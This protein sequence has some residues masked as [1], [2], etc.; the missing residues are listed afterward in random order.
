MRAR[1]RVVLLSTLWLGL[2]PASA[3]DL[4]TSGLGLWDTATTGWGT[5]TG[6][7]Y[8]GL[9]TH[10]ERAVFEGTA[11]SV[12]IG[13]G[14][15]TSAG[16]LFTTPGYTLG[17]GTLTLSTPGVIV[18]G[19]GVTTINSAI[20]SGG[21]P[22]LTKT[23]AGTL[24]L[25]G[26]NTFTG[27][28][29]IQQGVVN[30]AS[31][32]NY[33]VAGALG[34]RTLAMETAV[35]N[36]IG[37]H[38]NGGTLQ[39]TGST[40]QSTDRHIRLITGTSPTI[41]ASGTGAG[42]LSFTRTGPNLNL[43]DNPGTR[44]LNLIGSNTGN[45]SFSIRLENQ[46]ASQTTLRKA[47]VGKWVIANS[48]NTY[49]GETIFAG[50]IL[51]VASLSDYGVASSIGART[52]AEEN[53]GLTGVGLHFLGGTLQYTGATPQS[54]DRHIRILN[55][56]G[57]TID[58][59]G[60][61]P[62]A[63]LSFTRTGPNMN[64]FDTGGARTLTLTGT[65]PGDNTFSLRLENQGSNPTGLTKTGP[66]RWILNASDSTN[67]GLTLVRQG[68]LV[69][70]GARTAASGGITVADTTGQSATLDITAGSFSVGGNFMVAQGDSTVLGTVNQSGGS[71]SLAAD[72]MLVGNGPGGRGTYNL[73]AGTVTG[74]GSGTRGVILG[75]NTGT[76]GVFNLSGTGTLNLA[77][78]NLQVARSENTP[79]TNA[80]GVFNQTGG[81]ALVGTLGVG[82]QFAVN[83]AGSSGVVNLTGG[84]FTATGFNA[85]AGGDNSSAALTLGGSATVTLPAFPTARGSGATA[86]VL[87]DGGVL[88]AANSSATYLENMTW[89]RITNNGLTFDSNGQTVSINQA[90]E[91]QPSHTGFLTKNGGGT[92]T[93]GGA[94]A[95]TFT[96]WVTI[97]D[98]TLNLAKSSGL[99]IQGNV[100]IGNAVGSDVLRLGASDQIADSSVLTFTAG[101]AAGT[102]AFLQMNGQ[103]ETVAGIQTS[104]GGRVPVIENAGGGTGI[105]TVNNSA[106]FTFDGILRNSTGVF[107]LT[108]TGAGTLT[109][110]NTTTVA[111]I[112]Y[113]GPT[114]ISGGTLRLELRDSS[115]ASAVDN[116]STLDLFRA[117][118]NIN[119]VPAISGNG[120]LIKSGGGT[121]SLFGNSS[122]SGTT[123]LAG[124]RL[125]QQ[126]VN[127][128]GSG[129]VNIGAGN[130]TMLWW[131][132]G[133]NVLANPWVLNGVGGLRDGETKSAIYA[134]GGGAGFTAV[135]YVLTGPITLAATSDVGGWANTAFIA[136]N[137]LEISGE[138]GGP[139][140]LIKDYQN[141]VVLSGGTANTYGGDTTVK[142]GIL[143]LAKPDGVNA[144]PGNV[145]V[146]DGVVDAN[147]HHGD[148]LRLA[149]GNQ[150][151]DSAVLT[152]SGG[153]SAGTSGK[154]ELNGFNETV[155]GLA[156]TSPVGVVQI[157]ETA[158]AGQL[159]TLTINNATHHSYAGILRNSQNGLGEFSLVKN[160][161]GTQTLAGSSANTYTGLTTV[162]GGTLELAKSGGSNAVGGHLTIGDGIGTDTV[163]W[164][165]NNMVADAAIITFN[166]GGV[167]QING[168]N[169]SVG[170]L[171]STGG[172][173]V[174]DNAS[175]ASL[176]FALGGTQASP[177]AASGSFSGTLTESGGGSIHLVKNGTGTQIFTSTHSYTGKTTLNG[178]VL[179]ITSGN[180]NSLGQPAPAPDAL[181]LNGGT[182]AVSGANLTLN[183]PGRNTLV[184]IG[185]GTFSVASGRS[186]TLANT[187]DAT[188]TSLNKA[189]AGQL[190]LT[191]NTLVGT[192]NLDGG[193]TDISGGFLRVDTLNLSGGTFLWGSGR[194]TVRTA[195]AQN[196][197][198]DHTQPGYGEVRDGNTLQVNGDLT[199]TGGAILQ[200]HNS[201]T[202]YINNGVRF[203]GLNVEG[204]LD[205][206]AAG[207][208]LAVEINPY[209]LRPFA[210]SLGRAANEYG[211]IPLVTATAILGTF[212]TFG[213]VMDDGMGFSLTT[214]V[215]T[216]AAALDV[217]TWYLQYADTDNDLV[218]DTLFFHYRVAGYVPEPGSFS[219]LGGG[220]LLLR[221]LRRRWAGAGAATAPA[222]RPHRRRR[223]GARGERLL[224][225]LHP[226]PRVED[227]F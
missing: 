84:I 132:T 217:N 123:T 100:Q 191:G 39:Y 125:R 88:R 223:S 183:D 160:G 9:W 43:F 55:G 195:V 174:L 12:T 212:D 194:L 71:L 153:V 103:S 190:N 19:S 61:V 30:V 166:P 161:V 136:R 1:L 168:R 141:D 210:P 224:P 225:V 22:A 154:F 158:T 185:G 23:G 120:Q 98:G 155:A 32:T 3:A 215:F 111:P 109:L 124:G 116:D 35:G 213:S 145:I 69:L 95:N 142:N 135:P 75:V 201:P 164:S 172:A 151:P 208:R 45:N 80:T 5:T 156:G 165:A 119:F 49:T 58:A 134:D 214:N 18:P 27:V 178:G 207:D 181:I 76:Q 51:N 31:L 118:G 152:V 129:T 37:I 133:S 203:N 44:T 65:N 10:G 42:T 205:L 140:G 219:L 221:H 170:A 147:Y 7:P 137:S 227:R 171:Q 196:G 60:S 64:L 102:S 167:A 6:G 169:E 56:A 38:L 48:D 182:L 138:I 90:L 176:T 184:G 200:L 46:A 47:G 53:T 179:E 148:I 24:V 50:G 173:G 13:G 36:G 8:G 106:N 26:P 226:E 110:Q 150:I 2:R 206:S 104:V 218:A 74:A 52:L 4:F 15:V 40:P 99:A 66:G 54:T 175:A 73:S 143:V 189:G 67:T 91:N 126:H 188:G 122:Y 101:A 193:V 199:S 198:V 68:T 204:D 149:N 139:G 112:N 86:T 117:S 21:S 41:D 93:L 87:F 108:K 144:V 28:T 177:N 83:N 128:V 16:L 33:G 157:L 63:T 92:L 82:G 107:G 59:S 131:N 89:A 121:I 79:A 180:E 77:S 114:T 34:A 192:L 186:L 11:S 211:S 115:F 209:L 97:N 94:A 127:A 62:S 187:V 96:G 85:F 197:V 25:G 146:G 202:F 220:V 162:N 159:S 105:L 70:A 20:A 78:S 14:G 29:D 163:L 57:A 17:G 222:P 130:Y 72:Q 81:T 216:T 113:S